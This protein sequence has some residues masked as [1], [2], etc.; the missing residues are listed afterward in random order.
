MLEYFGPIYSSLPGLQDGSGWT[1]VERYRFAALG[2]ANQL[3]QSGDFCGAEY[4]YNTALSISPDDKIAP[5]ATYVALACRPP[6]AT[7]EP[8]RAVTAAPTQEA[9]QPT[10]EIPTGEVPTEETPAGETPGGE[11]TDGE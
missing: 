4:Y 5:T 2:Y 11:A 10:Q 9:P 7:P 8:T 6:T 1:V 3:A